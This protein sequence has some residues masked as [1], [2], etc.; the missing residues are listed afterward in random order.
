MVKKL[1]FLLISFVLLSCSHKQREEQAQ[2]KNLFEQGQYDQALKVLEKSTLKS[3]KE[4]KLL[5]L[6]Q[7]GKILY[8]KGQFFEASLIFLEASD[9]MDKLYTKKV[10]EILMSGILN[11]NSKSYRGQ[12]YERSLLF[13]YQAQS[14]L[15]IYQAGKYKRLKKKVVKDKKVEYFE[16]Q[17][18]SAS[19]KRQELFK[20]RAA[21]VAWD[22]FYKE[23]Q[24]SKSKSSFKHDLFAKILAGQV[25]ELVNKRADGQIALQL[26]KDA[27]KILRDIGPSLESFN[28]THDKYHKELWDK[29]KPNKKLK[30]LTM[31][32]ND[33]ESYL[34][35]KILQMT[36]KYRSY[37]FKKLRRRYSKNQNAL[38]FY[39]SLGKKKVIIETRTIAPL[40]GEDF[41]YNLRS[42]VDSVESPAAKAF[43]S[44]VGVPVLTYFAMGPLGLGSV[45]SAGNTRVYVRHGVGEAMVSEA[46]IEFEMP[47][48]ESNPGNKFTKLYFFKKDKKVDYKKAPVAASQNMH[49]V[50]PLSDM[51]YMMNKEMISNSFGKRGV[52]I[53]V[54][55]IV[56]IIAAYKTYETIKKNSGE[57][58]AKPAAFAQYLAS[59]KAIK[60]TEKADTRQW[61]TLPSEILMAE[62]DLKNGEY[63]AVIGDQDKKLM[64]KVGDVVISDQKPELISLIAR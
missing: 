7:K 8:A 25:H 62:V 21:V 35:A 5:Y 44:A 45:S 56:A 54:K 14:H 16:E 20:A 28:S 39:K 47:V 22:T 61:S 4:N 17:V 24:R 49:L 18:L 53:A 29:G 15:K 10:R 43:I 30:S 34:M 59:A 2:L 42:A 41:S 26:Y 13:Y 1:S 3:E 33:L 9:K 50:G 32:Y 40:I 38:K 23:I 58:F 31:T 64:K 11:E 57:L 60:A 52:R 36:K 55:H 51:A 27:Y 48:I 6:L 37:E 12:I 46:G 19:Q 63:I